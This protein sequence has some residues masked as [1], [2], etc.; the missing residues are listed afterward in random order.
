MKKRLTGALLSA[1]I[2]ASAVLPAMGAGMVSAEEGND[3]AVNLPLEA[4]YDQ[5]AEMTHTGWEQHGTPLGNGFIGA[6]VFGGVATDKIQ[7]NEH[8]LWSGGPGSSAEYDGGVK[9]TQAEHFE[10]LQWVRAELQKVSNAMAAD[11]KA[12]PEKAGKVSYDQY[13]G[14][15]GVNKSQVD[16]AIQSLYGEKAHFGSY[17]TL[18][19]IYIA[20][21]RKNDESKHYRR[22][23][24]LNDGTAKVSY[25]QNGVTYTREYFVSNPGNVM[26]VR[27]TASEKGRLTREISIDSEQ[28]QKSIY[29]DLQANTITMVGRSSDQGENGLKFAQQLKVVTK[30][31]SALTLGDTVYVDE[32]DE[33]LI[34]MTAGTN[35]QLQTDGSYDFFKDEDPLDA[36]SARIEAAAAKGYEGVLREH[37]ADYQAL[38]GAMQLNI[39]GM[40]KVPDKPTDEL[41]N[42]YRARF[43]AASKTA[44]D[45][46]GDYDW[47]T[48]EDLYLENLYFQF[49]RYLLIAS[50]RAGSLPANLQGIWADS[51]TPPWSADYHTNINLQMNYWLAEQTNLAECHIPVIEYVAAQMKYGKVIARQYYCDRNG[52]P[53]RGWTFHHENNIWGNSAPGESG[54]SYAPESAAW[55]CQDI[56]EY[57]QFNQDKQFLADNYEV[58]LGAALFWVD[59]LV[60]DAT[61]GTLVASPSYSPEHGPFTLGATFVQAVVWEI[62]NEV[63]QASEILDK[64]SAEVDEIKA[65]QAKL[66]GPKIGVNG[67]FMEW[68]YETSQDVS[69]DG[70]HRHT[71]HLYPLHPGNQIVAGRSEEE[72]AFVEAMK[73]TLNTRTDNGTGWSKA[74][75]INFWARTRVGDRTHK[76]VSSLLG[77]LTPDG[78]TY[79]TADNLFDM[80][81]PFQIDGNFGATAGMAEMLLQSQGDAVE[82]LPALPQAW[83]SGTATGLKA[84]GNVE[85]DMQ[86]SHG[87][88]GTA[89]LRPNVDNA[90]LKVKGTNIANGKLVDSKGNDVAFTADGTNTIVFAAKAG[91]TYTIADIV[92]PEGLANAKAALTA[93]IADAEDAVDARDPEDPLN[94]ADANQAMA[95]AIAA[96]KQTLPSNNLYDLLEGIDRLQAAL[97]E[98]RQAYTLSLEVDDGGFFTGV[99]SVKMTCPS[100]LVDIRYTTD[101]TEPGAASTAYA[102]P[103][104]LPFGWTT[105]KAAIFYNAEKVSDTVERE[106]FVVPET[107]LAQGKTVTT[108]STK[109][110][111]GYPV[112]QIVN[113]KRNNRWATN[114]NSGED[115]DAIINFG[116]PTTFD[117][118]W[119]DEFC[120]TNQATR[121]TSLKLEYLDGSTWKEI[122]LEAGKHYVDNVPNSPTASQ[123]AHK[124]AVFPPV[125]AQQVRLTMR[126]ND[127]SI[128]ELSFYNT[129]AKGD[130]TA[131]NALIDEVKALDLSVYEDTAALEAALAAAEA[132]KADP[133][134]TVTDVA[135]AT[136]NLQNA[137]AALAEKAVEQILLGDVDGNGSVTAADALM[138]LQAA[139]GKIVLDDEQTARADVDGNEGVTAADALMI[140]Q[141]ATGKIVLSDEPAEPEDPVLPD[142][143]L[144]LPTATKEQ[145][146]EAMNEPVDPAKYTPE[147]VQAYQQAMAACQMLIDN[148][149]VSGA[150]LYRALT[151]LKAAKSGLA[152]NPQ[153][154]WVGTFS[155]ISGNHTVLGQGQNLLYADWKQIDQG[156]VDCTD[157]GNLRLQLTITL[158]STNPDVDPATMWNELV[159]KLRSSDKAGVAGDPDGSGNTEHNYG[160]NFQRSSI[161]NGTATLNVSIPL[162]RAKGNSRGVMDWSDVGRIIIQCWLDGNKTPGDKYQYTMNVSNVRIVDQG[163]IDEAK[164]TLSAKVDEVKNV[165]TAGKPADKVAAFQSALSAAQTLLAKPETVIG[166]VGAPVSLYDVN[167]A[168]TDL[169]DAYNALG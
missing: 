8:T 86:W 76:V 34:Y 1:A 145:V 161:A 98:F 148:P 70:Q 35:Y 121:V 52:D 47:Y 150:N 58:L 42:N 57:Y 12:H 30:G 41:L 45:P 77:G 2:L 51:L 15:A 55:A 9:G 49:G 152:E 24:N 133:N 159:I 14:T 81:A 167:K 163:A 143:P 153:P 22:S 69:G 3:M 140:L 127:I 146:Q 48:P 123:H 92:D 18:G 129:S 32:A 46:N 54:A 29:G 31:G 104:V 10:T 37:K 134:A 23:L 97:D 102:G 28:P 101:G 165:A 20:D 116:T 151:A 62:F 164:A 65:A 80:H 13:Y 109:T 63:I 16:A 61:D 11:L 33:I 117:C 66:S 59:N 19:N 74:W 168:L 75:K 88:I 68:K 103:V 90:A 67:Q 7:V 166:S 147:T 40:T 160:W 138:A 27:L 73:Q 38:F 111:N 107:D 25:K 137:V 78:S 91:E 142:A 71:N 135:I 144:N 72:D 6:M 162:D 110:I 114:S 99:T 26:V 119:L 131:L 112:T 56:W 85:V 128:W 115:T 130:K 122:D 43:A 83:N 95:D 125:T 87:L 141:A 60:E 36:V 108:T 64:P 158:Q 156:S 106:F 124:T 126:G 96:A 4:W 105:V 149:N 84:R 157:R 89:V 53:V 169:T 132:V 120:E 5:P 118:F 39:S 50:S 79:S 82:L 136:G 21:P 139:T 44:I 17:Q 93:L 113:G 155:K 94:D 100:K 154:N